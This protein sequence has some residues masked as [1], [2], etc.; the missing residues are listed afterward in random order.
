[1]YL[2]SLL[3]YYSLFSLIAK[4]QL[5]LSRYILLWN[6]GQYVCLAVVVIDRTDTIS[7]IEG[8]QSDDSVTCLAKSS[9]VLSKL[10]QVGRGGGA[11]PFLSLRAFGNIMIVEFTAFYTNMKGWS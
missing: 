1:M 10:N 11:L 7:T 6:R 9:D 8:L 4:R 5:V 3:H 2:E